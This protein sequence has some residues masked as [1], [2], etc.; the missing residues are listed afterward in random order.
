MPLLHAKESKALLDSGFHALDSG[1][2]VLYL[3]LLLELVFWIPIDSGI[4]DSRI[5][6]FSH[7][8]FYRQKSGRQKSGFLYMGR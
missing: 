2:H 7:V 3:L 1:F 4:L 6:Y 8:G 5:K